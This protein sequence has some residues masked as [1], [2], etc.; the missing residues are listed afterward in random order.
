[1][2]SSSP[3][4]RP[5][6]RSSQP[7]GSVPTIDIATSPAPV[8]GLGIEEWRPFT[9]AAAAAAVLSIAFIVWTT[10]RIGGDTA[11]IAVDDIGEAVAALIAAGS[12]GYAAFRTSER[13]RLAW[14]LFAI[15]A[16]S[17][18][19]GETAWSV[20]EVGLGQ[21]VPSPSIAD[22]GFVIAIPFAIAGIFAFTS[23][24]TRLT[25]RGEALLASAIVALSLLFV[26]WALG[27]GQVYATSGE[28]LGAQLI[29]LLYPVSDIVTVT[30][31]VLALRRARRTE[32]GRMVLL[33]GGVASAALADS[34]F[35]YLNANGT[36]GAI[37]SVL[38][39]GWVV[40]YL[41][42]ALAPLWPAA[43][44]ETARREGPIG[45]WQLALPWAAVAFAAL[46]AFRLALLD[47]NLDRFSTVL[48]AAVGIL[49]VGNQVLSH[50]DSLSLLVKSHA[51]ERQ[52]ARR[53]QL[54]DQIITHAP[55]GI[56][57][58]GTD[59]R[60]ID[61]NPRMA[62]LLHADANDV[63]GSPVSRFIGSEEFSRVFSIFQPL[64]KGTADTIESD[65]H[66]IRSDG[67]AA[68]L[69]WSATGVRNS[70]GRIEYFLAMYEDTDA[71]HAANEA[72]AAHLAGLERLN[73]L[74]SEFVSL[75]SHEFRTALVGIQGFSEMI[76]D[77]DVSVAEAKGYAADI[78]SDAERLNRMINDMLDLDR[79]EA[80]RLTM[81]IGA[82]RINGVLEQAIDR[83][84]A[85][86][87]KH[88]IV[89]DLDPSDPIVAADADRLAQVVANLLSNAMK[90]SPSGGEVSVTSRAGTTHVDVGV[91]DHGLGIAPEFVK[92]LFNRYERYEKTSARILGTGLGLAITRQIIEMHGGK[93][94]V[95]SELGKGSDFHFT[96][97]VS[98]QVPD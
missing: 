17:W 49:M 53:N 4:Y 22:I 85:S 14:S 89:S 30:I 28:T 54:L 79:I 23:S 1:M 15:S 44:E 21:A 92:R 45:L 60:I 67:T 57:R 82:V 56:A 26:A 87:T 41:L 71:E 25:S 64:W 16:L 98:Q 2:K 78:N 90:Y 58:V 3:T 61:V 42:I 59:M 66:V 29:G 55:L 43:H 36:Y 10:L 65:S 20:I 91:R 5:P 24:P 80:G 93:I 27:L 47:R 96:V 50:R 73:E 8:A 38:D 51:V 74:K 48:A 9:I 77:E 46:M 31:L 94:W 19:L 63:V 11:T 84:R 18:G 7:A 95:D 88:S 35:A 70:V 34:A 33:L 37:G 72:A 75:V 68:W 6:P 39:A 83:A 69:H 81:H 13:T 32:L 86:T 76:R 40:G 97:P 12:C 52:L 62:S